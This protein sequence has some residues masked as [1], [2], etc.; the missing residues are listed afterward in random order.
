MSRFS[1]LSDSEK[2]RILAMLEDCT[3]YSIPLN[4]NDTFNYGADSE[5]CDFPDFLAVTELHEK[6]GASGVDAWVAVKRSI[7]YKEMCD[8]L[9]KRM[10]D[11]YLQAKEQILADP[12]KYYWHER[13]KAEKEATKK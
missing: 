9:P 5:D 3:Y 7:E 13:R 6:Y 12:L 1:N 8:V 4:V 10:C 11:K 2:L